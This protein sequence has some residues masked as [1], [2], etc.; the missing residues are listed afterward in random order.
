MID[1]RPTG[2]MS[3]RRLRQKWLKFGED[4]TDF[5]PDFEQVIRHE[6]SLNA[7]ERYR[8]GDIAVHVHF[9]V[10]PG[11]GQGYPTELCAVFAKD[12][13]LKLDHR[14]RRRA[15]FI[16]D[17]K[18]RNL[19]RQWELS[20]VR[21]S[22]IGMKKF[23][24]VSVVN[25]SQSGEGMC[26]SFVPSQVWL[27]FLDDC[28][29]TLEQS[30][31]ALARAAFPSIRKVGN[32]VSGVFGA[33]I[34]PLFDQSPNEIVE[35]GPKLMSP[36]AE[37]NAPFSGWLADKAEH[38]LAGLYIEVSLY[39]AACGFNERRDFAVEQCEV[40]I[41]ALKAPTPSF[42]GGIHE[43]KEKRPEAEDAPGASRR[44]GVRA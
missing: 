9:R 29:I 17:G 7:G 22:R 4:F 41:C 27:T 15:G 40:M 5:A 28:Q 34:P 26:E 31:Q 23:V 33:L 20:H 1:A 12:G 32:N 44:S 13:I 11:I 19:R 30:P 38:I 3:T 39:G 2:Q 43:A 36:F 8:D 10:R 37:S 16:E 42:K 6:G 24:L 35:N 25:P 18:A 21:G 14:D